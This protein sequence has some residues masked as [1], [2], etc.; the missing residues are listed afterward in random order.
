M[1]YSLLNNNLYPVEYGV[2]YGSIVGPIHE[3]INDTTTL[4]SH[5]EPISVSRNL[6]AATKI[7]CKFRWKLQSIERMWK[8]L[9]GLRKHKDS[10]LLMSRIKSILLF[11]IPRNIYE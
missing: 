2:S 6:Q 9:I 11:N 4:A 10:V 3:N 7:I 8:N 1:G 5:L